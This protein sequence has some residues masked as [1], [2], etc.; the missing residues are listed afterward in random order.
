[1]TP[2][3]VA[4]VAPLAPLAS[5]ESTIEDMQSEITD[6]NPTGKQWYR[7]GF[8]VIIFGVLYFIVKK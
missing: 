8:I 1:M 3:P 7:I 4:P 2:D 5:D 6:I